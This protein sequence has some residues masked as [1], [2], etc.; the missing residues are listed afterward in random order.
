MTEQE[1]RA[2]IHEHHKNLGKL[3]GTARYQKYGRQGMRA[4]VNK[5]WGNPLNKVGSRYKGNQ[6]EN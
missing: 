5:R 4:M 1:K 6:N 3:G 2:V